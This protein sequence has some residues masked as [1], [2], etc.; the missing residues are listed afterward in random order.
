MHGRP[1]QFRC[2]LL[3]EYPGQTVQWLHD[4]HPLTIDRAFTSDGQTCVLKISDVHLEDEGVF[5][6]VVRTPRGASSCSAKLTVL[7]MCVWSGVYIGTSVHIVPA[8]VLLT[9]PLAW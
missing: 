6:C 7:G 5:T 1:V 3:Q 4:G 9:L 8:Q 2:Q